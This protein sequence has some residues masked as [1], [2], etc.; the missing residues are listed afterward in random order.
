MI[1]I[2]HES[3]KIPLQKFNGELPVTDMMIPTTS[4][5]LEETVDL[6]CN[7]LDIP[8]YE[9]GRLDA[10]HLL[11]ETFIDYKRISRSRF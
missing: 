10:L 1:K 11:F 8:V 7:L 4:C 2:S 5:T 6:V 3:I 9:E